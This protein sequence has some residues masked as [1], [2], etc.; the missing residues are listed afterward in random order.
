MIRQVS[1]LKL[2]ENLQIEQAIKRP[3]VFFQTGRKSLIIIT[4]AEP[5]V[6]YRQKAPRGYR[7]N[8]KKEKIEARFD[9]GNCIRCLGT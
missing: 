9:T 2:F 8:R 4:W 6:S 7:E 3:F 1:S 5:Q